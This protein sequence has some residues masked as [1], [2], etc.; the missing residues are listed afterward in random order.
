MATKKE[1]MNECL[2]LVR[3]LAVLRIGEVTHAEVREMLSELKE[4][5]KEAEDESKAK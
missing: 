4:E 3:K 1:M 5:V 2:K